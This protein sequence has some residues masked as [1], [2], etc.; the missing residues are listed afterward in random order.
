MIMNSWDNFKKTYKQSNK[1]NWIKEIYTD[2]SLSEDES[3]EFGELSEDICLCISDALKKKKFTLV[4]NKKETSY[5]Y[6]NNIIYWNIS[7]SKDVIIT[8]F[9][10]ELGHVVEHQNPEIL[11]WSLAFVCD[12]SGKNIDD[13]KQ[14]TSIK[15]NVWFSGNFIEPYVGKVYKTDATEIISMGFQYLYNNKEVF[16]Q[17]DEYHYLMIDFILKNGTLPK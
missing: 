6:K 4:L 14:E 16:K 11:N 8:E 3:L 17:K 12:R 2:D 13:I 5:D 7:K 15:N 9:L 10:H 1:K